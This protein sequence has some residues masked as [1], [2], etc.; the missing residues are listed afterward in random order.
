MPPGRLETGRGDRLRRKTA[1]CGSPRIRRH[2]MRIIFVLTIVPPGSIIYVKSNIDIG[3][4]EE[5]ASGLF[6]PESGRN[7][8]QPPP[9]SLYRECRLGAVPLNDDAYGSGVQ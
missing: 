2:D 5:K 3:Y 8:L 6:R 7:M 9:K 1:V 4:D